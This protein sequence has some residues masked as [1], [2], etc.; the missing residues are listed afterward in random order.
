MENK[1]MDKP[2]HTHSVREDFK[3]WRAIF[4]GT[5]EECRKHTEDLMNSAGKQLPLILTENSKW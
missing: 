4:E 5:E 1:D 3:P 2:T